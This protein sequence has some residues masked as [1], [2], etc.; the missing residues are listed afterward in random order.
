MSKV[1][2]L[3]GYKATPVGLNERKFGIE[4]ELEQVHDFSAESIPGCAMVVE[5]N[6]LRHAGREFISHPLAFEDVLPFYNGV[7]HSSDVKWHEKSLRCN[8]RCSI[9]VHVNTLYMEQEAVITVLRLYAMLEAGFFAAVA[10]HR[11]NNIYCVPLYATKQMH[12][13]YNYADDLTNIIESWHKYAALNARPLGGLGTIEFR[14]L[15]ATEDPNV[16]LRWITSIN[17]LFD[18]AAKL[19]NADLSFPEVLQIYHTVFNN[20]PSSEVLDLLRLCHQEDVLYRSRIDVRTLTNRIAASKKETV[21]V[22][23]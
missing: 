8:E 17:C 19:R 5:D 12:H 18:K 20:T 22:E 6:S 4:L 15:Q 23:A 1:Y 3:L 21:S 16:L 7:M 10:P 9:H 2:A 11:H 14:H 13:V